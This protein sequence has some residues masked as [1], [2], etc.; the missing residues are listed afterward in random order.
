MRVLNHDTRLVNGL[1]GRPRD[2]AWP[3]HAF[4][5]NLPIQRTGDNSL[6]PFERVI[7]KLI[8]IEGFHGEQ[9]LA[10]ESCLPSPLVRSILSKLRTRGI[11]DK[12]NQLIERTGIPSRANDQPIECATAIVFRELIGGK[13]LP[14]LR[15]LSQGSPLEFKD[16]DEG[17]IRK[18]HH[19]SNAGT[20]S[21][22]S[23]REVQNIFRLSR[24]RERIQTRQSLIPNVSQI[25]VLEEPESYLLRCQV[26]ISSNNAK[27]LVAD[28]FSGRISRELM[29][30][31]ETR[32]L[33]DEAL[34]RWVDNWRDR[35]VADQNKRHTDSD[36]ATTEKKSGQLSPFPGLMSNLEIPPG[37]TFRDC[38]RTY[39][40]LEYCLYYLSKLHD[41]TNTIRT[42]QWLNENTFESQL[43]QAAEIVG[44]SYEPN[45][46]H[47]V[48]RGKLDDYENQK[49]ELETVL[50]ICI[51]QAE[52]DKKHPLRVLATKNP[53]FLA[54]VRELRYLRGLGSHVGV[55][56]PWESDHKR[57]D[58]FLSETITT[59]LPNV[60]IEIGVAISQLDESSNL[61]LL[62]RNSLAA[63]L[64]HRCLVDV[65]SSVEEA[66]FRAEVFGNAAASGKNAIG[67]VVDLC[68]ALQGVFELICDQ[69]RKATDFLEPPEV[70]L[71]R[72]ESRAAEFR[73]EGFDDSFRTVSPKRL[74]R[75]LRGEDTTLG[76]LIIAFLLSARDGDLMWL[77]ERDPEI[78][79][80]CS[81]LLKLRGHGNQRVDLTN[82]R[83]QGLLDATTHSISKLMELRG[84]G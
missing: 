66:L 12:E 55:K 38:N 16:F 59:L 28:P 82:Q 1:I 62:A 11:L 81:E 70:L 7:L 83:I 78:L 42:M 52:S 77:A 40:S 72:S 51:L 75:A 64:G 67:F 39:A 48:K 34:Q 21:V 15:V 2:L 6:N 27:I 49:A 20:V 61:K 30:V 45:L 9:I 57:W 32:L 23:A 17:K 79:R 19:G 26:G 69:N 44:F 74:S 31:F 84:E 53:R 80:N 36:G 50:T 22:P 60:K 5:L 56:T 24:K 47:C 33:E 73:L 18:M 3:V 68:S 29:D 71:S 43:K 37:H 54:D 10:E 58:D 41:W 14:G 25:Q 46:L 13:L 8:E 76:A 65:G 4:R 35:L 63:R